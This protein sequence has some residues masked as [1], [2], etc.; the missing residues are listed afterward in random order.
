MENM[1]HFVFQNF[2]CEIHY[3]YRKG[4]EKKWVLFFHGAGVD[5]RMFEA[6]FGIFDSTYNIIAW[7]ARGQGLSKLEGG[8]RF[9]FS[10]MVS[11]CKK[12]YELYHI[13]KAILIGQSMGGN[14]AQEIAYYSPE[15]T[16]K[17]VLIDCTK[18]T[19]KLTG[20]E[21]LQLKTARF[22]FACYPWKTLLRQSAK[23]SANKDSVRDYISG[24]FKILGKQTFVDIMME[25]VVG[26][27]HEDMDY[28]FRQ[29]VLLICGADDKLGNIRKTARPWAEE[30]KSILFYEIQDAGHNSNQDQ[31]EI[32]N[33]RIRDF[34][35]LQKCEV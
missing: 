32:V 26:C 13:D 1:E 29:P 17:L 9:L 4:S 24:C 22:A 23:A 21:K 33:M 27:L 34:L 16:D 20:A 35:N 5:H 6:Q 3:W 31:P 11:D 15:L 14:L 18:N 12:L 7:D 25:L 28:F 10:D 30:D 2:G 8:R 19:V